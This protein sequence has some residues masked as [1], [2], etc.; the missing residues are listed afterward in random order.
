MP[1]C[2][3]RLNAGN[4]KYA[5]QVTAADVDQCRKPAIVQIAHPPQVVMAGSWFYCRATQSATKRASGARRLAV[6]ACLLILFGGAVVL[7]LDVTAIFG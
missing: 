1:P 2:K 6:V 7:A 5:I 3:A 4:I